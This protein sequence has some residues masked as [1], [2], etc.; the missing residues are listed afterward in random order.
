MLKK[1]LFRIFLTLTVLGILSGAV[2]YLLIIAGFFGPMPS[3]HALERIIQETASL[4]YDDH[5]ELLGKYF[6]QDRTN[7]SID[8]IPDYIKNALI[9]TED[10]RFYKH[11]GV[12]TRSLGRVFLKTILLQKGAGGGSTITQQLA[13]NLF[14]RSSYG[15]LTIPIN[16]TKEIILAK[17]LEDVYE[18][19]QI[20]EVYLNLVPFGENVY[21][22]ESAAQRYFNKHAANLKIEEAAVLIGILKANTTYNP[23]LHP[24]KSEERRNVV[25]GQML[26]NEFIS[27]SEFDE[28]VALPLVIDYANKET[29]G[30]A[31]Y[32]LKQVK[33]EANFIIE[34]YNKRHLREL[35]LETDGL[36]I[37]T[38]LDSK[39][40]TLAIAAMEK[41]L[42]KMQALLS[43]QYKS[44]ISKREVL[45]MA[46]A[47]LKQK[48]Q[49]ERVN[50]KTKFTIF[51][52]NGLSLK[53][54][55]VMDSLIH[56]YTRLQAGILAID[57]RSGA[58]KT[59]VGGVDFRTQ[60]FDQIQARRQMASSFKPL[61]YAAGLEDGTMPC[62][63]LS[64]EPVVLED[65]QDWS[66][67]NYD[68]SNEGGRYAMKT[69]L[70]KSLNIPTLH[71][72]FQVGHRKLNRLWEELEFKTTLPDQPS[73]ALGTAEAN[74]IELARLYSVF[75]NGGKL[76]ETHYIQ[77]IETKDGEVIFEHES[78]KQTQVMSEQT[79]GLMRQMLEQT[80]KSGTAQGIRTRFGFKHELAAKTGTNQ[81][82]A[83]AWFCAFSPDLVLVSRVGCSSPSIHFNNGL[84]G[85][86]SALALPLIGYTLL[87]AQ[88]DPNLASRYFNRFN[89]VNDVSLDCPDFKKAGVIDQVFKLFG[90][91]KTTLEKERK[92]AELKQGIRKG[93]RGL[94]GK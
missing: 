8:S 73:A 84:N 67:D 92:K 15:K 40:Q 6:K 2:F 7:I 69:A 49:A 38:T 25:L 93:V 1:W 39:M 54:G 42:S 45:A 13:K 81:N 87:Q 18:K 70:A 78:K 41:H 65:F 22:I 34:K 91:D 29:V 3:K 77:R 51:D 60:P 19:D 21:G 12:D 89:H 20:L 86:G 52:W 32:F 36:V 27:Q 28:L 57:P 30:I 59:Y 16:K 62:D 9:A 88:K 4:V 72:Y 35:D 14:G 10:E 75:V 68:K 23:R 26:R 55:T 50:L 79:A 90:K 31:D 66:P 63:Y 61:L 17:R 82:Y 48:N 11:E 24:D 74:M 53:A 33:S 80:V 64:N 37:E 83:D 85:S 46:E 58:I 43:K 56:H 44:G 94:F 76:A 5:G 47:Y 71:L